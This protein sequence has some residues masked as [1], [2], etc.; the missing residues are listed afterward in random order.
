[1][2]SIKYL[3]IQMYSCIFSLLTTYYELIITNINGKITKLLKVK[4]SAI[5]IKFE[6]PK[7]ILIM[8]SKKEVNSLEN[9][10]NNN[11]NSK[12]NQKKTKL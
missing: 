5:E 6:D 8:Y 11:R 4:L 12:C 3:N 2:S 1:M 10:N 7:V 9:S